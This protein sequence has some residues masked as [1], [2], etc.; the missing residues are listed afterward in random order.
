MKKARLL[1]GLLL[2]A[3][4]LTGT[5]PAAW[6]A[7]ADYDG[8]YAGTYS[9]D[10][11]SE[12]GYWVALI[13]SGG[14]SDFLSYSPG[15]GTGDTG[16]LDYRGEVTW[17]GDV[18]GQF[19]DDATDLQGNLVIVLVDSDDG[20]VEG[21]WE[22]NANSQT[23]TL[24]GDQL[25]AGAFSGD[26]SGSYDGDDTGTWTLDVG[27]DGD[28]TGTLSSDSSGDSTFTGGYNRDGYI[29]AAGP[30]Y[31]VFM[32]I[33]DSDVSGVWMAD[34][35]SEGTITGTINLVDNSPADSGDDNDSDG[36][37]GGGSSSGCF[38]H[39]LAGE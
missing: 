39:S 24:V 22:N 38:L 1:A 18:A 15:A 30:D 32:E 20:S 13:D 6:S 9:S 16:T 2:A 27:A 23:G 21:A 14:S 5:V 4:L 10:D 33:S 34:D 25:A 35:D 3:V 31:G 28:I 7:E 19:K 11:N 37:G 8:N 12:N 29:L 36:G 17:G 26:G